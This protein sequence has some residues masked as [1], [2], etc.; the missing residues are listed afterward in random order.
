LLPS[1]IRELTDGGIASATFAWIPLVTNKSADS[2]PVTSPIPLI[3]PVQRIC[4]NLC[5]KVQA[6]QVQADQ[7]FQT[8]V[9]HVERACL[10]ASRLLGTGDWL[11]AMPLSSI[12]LKLDNASVRIAYW[13][14]TWFTYLSS[15]QVHSSLFVSGRQFKQYK[16]IQ[17]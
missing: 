8:G 1:R 6:D 9:H 12:G 3:S 5:C 13:S 16:Q 10:L 14:G 7:L 17:K 11:N 4:D 2:I 15:A